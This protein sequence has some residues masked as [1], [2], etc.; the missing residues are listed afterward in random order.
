MPKRRA[1]AVPGEFDTSDRNT[2]ENPM[3]PAYR[4]DPTC[5]S[6]P[7]IGK[8]PWHATPGNPLGGASGAA[9]LAQHLA[10]GGRI[11]VVTRAQPLE[12]VGMDAIRALEPALEL[13]ERPAAARIV[14]AHEKIVPLDGVEEQ[15][16]LVHAEKE[17]SREV[18]QVEEPTGSWLDL[19]GTS[20]GWDEVPTS[21]RRT[22]PSARPMPA[23]NLGRAGA[24]RGRRRVKWTRRVATTRWL[25]LRAAPWPRRIPGA[26]GRA[27]CG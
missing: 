20:P 27:S 15:R 4:S 1:P 24:T 19:G 8:A 12:R 21:R 13:Q 6:D 17:G 23:K 18:G 25:R 26:C 14:A 2:R 16:V 11:Q 5:P 3:S 7:R 9:P 22:S 10:N